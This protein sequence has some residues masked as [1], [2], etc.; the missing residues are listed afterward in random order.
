MNNTDGS[1]VMRFA[2]VLLLLI[3]PMLSQGEVYRW[4]DEKGQVHFGSVPPNKQNPY[5]T[6]ALQENGTS[7]EAEI[8]HSQPKPDPKVVSPNRGEPQKSKQSVKATESSKNGEGDDQKIKVIYKPK[9]EEEKRLALEKEKQRNEKFNALINRLRTSLGVNKNTQQ[10]PGVE[11]KAKTQKADTL[12]KPDALDNTGVLN[13]E[14]S[15]T[16]SVE[17]TE[18]QTGTPSNEDIEKENEV[19]ME[20]E[21]VEKAEVKDAEKCGFF[22]SFVEN[23]EDRVRYECPSDYCDTLQMK[24]E[25][26]RSKAK[27]Y[28]GSENS[29]TVASEA[30]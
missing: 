9:T 20:I 1:V 14:N 30:N 10:E 4:V 3:F 21:S 25:K 15:Q 17:N 29:E 27:Q 28:C 16:V 19:R 11:A 8:K 23:Y 22:L 7:Q 13:N 12:D 6:G 18:P 26:Y 2:V 5:K 24:L